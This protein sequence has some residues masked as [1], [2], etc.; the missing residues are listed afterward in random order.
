MIGIFAACTT[1]QAQTPPRVIDLPSR[2]GV[3]QRLLLL[4][5]PEP[6]AT[7]LLFTGGHGGLQVAADGTFK[8]GHGNFLIRS[9]ELF[10][11]QGL[12]VALIDAPSDLQS[13]PFLQGARQRPE[14]VADVRSAIVWL[15][16]TVKQPVWLVGTSRG[17]QSV[18]YVATELS[19][20]QAPDGIV[21]SA[22]V[23]VDRKD[24][25]VSALPLA[26]IAIPVLV[27]HHE[28]DACSACPFSQVPAL[29]SALTHS[30]RKQLLVFNGGLNTG[31][32]C[33]AFAHHGFNGLESDVVGRIAAWVTARQ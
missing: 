21:L 25:P 31:D 32:P 23:V 19:G 33:E 14:H 24:R 1:A 26:R 13:P 7:V 29:M 11:Q 17:T 22:T 20:E 30:P 4:T 10:L 15:R 12:A 16:Q 6:R 28:Q 2:A 18:A 8:R 9:R 3:T 27:V 5:P